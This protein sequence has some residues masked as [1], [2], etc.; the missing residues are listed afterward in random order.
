MVALCSSLTVPAPSRRNPQY[1][2]G[3]SGGEP[4]P[5]GREGQF[6]PPWPQEAGSL[7]GPRQWSLTRDLPAAHFSATKPTGPPYATRSHLLLL[8]QAA[9]VQL[10]GMEG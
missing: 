2:H 7:A 3:H 10:E 1:C 9:A 4:A 6:S 8:A 5:E